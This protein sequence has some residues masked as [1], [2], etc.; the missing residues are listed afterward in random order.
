M[1]FILNV[2]VLLLRIIMRQGCV[3]RLMRCQCFKLSS[4]INRLL[5]PFCKQEFL[6]ETRLLERVDG[7]LRHTMQFRSRATKCAGSARPFQRERWHISPQGRLLSLL[8][9]DSR[10]GEVRK[11]IPTE[12][13]LRWRRNYRIRS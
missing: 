13:R 7:P 2:D 12:R 11:T 3:S 8:A 5:G 10:T 6:E 1:E 4:R 9:L